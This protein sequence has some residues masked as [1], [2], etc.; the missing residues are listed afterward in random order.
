MPVLK[1]LADP[2]RTYTR[3]ANIADIEV[4][5][6]H[7]AGGE[8]I[9]FTIE[10]LLSAYNLGIEFDTAKG[11]LAGVINDTVRTN[12]GVPHDFNITAE[13]SGGVATPIPVTII[14][15]DKVPALTG[16][17]VDPATYSRGTA[18]TANPVLSQTDRSVAG[19]PVAFVLSPPLPNDLGLS[20]NS[21][22]GL[23]SG[24][25]TRLTEDQNKDGVPDEMLFSISANNSGGVSNAIQ[26]T[27]KVVDIPPILYSYTFPVWHTVKGQLLSAAN[28]PNATGIITSFESQPTL[29]SGLVLNST[30]GAISG[31]PA[32]QSVLTTYVIRASNTGGSSSLMVNISVHPV[33]SIVAFGNPLFR[34]T[35]GAPM[36]P[37]TA[38]LANDMDADLVYQVHPELPRG[39]SLN[40]KTGVISGT[41]L[42]S[43]EQRYVIT[44]AHHGQ[45][46]TAA[47]HLTADKPGTTPPCFCLFLLPF[48]YTHSRFHL[49]H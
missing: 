48:C 21:S 2:V 13:N 42:S 10:P 45:R 35:V 17:L 44:A 19:A 28:V 14:V 3:G 27:L 41:A 31:T 15:V 49:V 24:T 8:A 40:A 47:L 22:S 26:L 5:V 9:A 25:P 38:I 7:T 20:F 11:K 18:I 4:P 43:T 6:N 33:L 1:A 39:L 23:L 46:S 36:A 29:P 30:T 37:I 34:A 12:Y 16:M 32:S